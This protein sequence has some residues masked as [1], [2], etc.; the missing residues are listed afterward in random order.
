[1]RIGEEMKEKKEDVGVVIGRFQVDNLHEAHKALLNSVAES[2]GR[3]IIMIGLS[4][5][6]CTFSNPLDFDTRRA[7]LQEHYPKATIMYIN[8]IHD[9][10]IWSNDLD[11]KISNLIGPA[12]SVCMYGSR[13][14]F[15][16]Y[17]HGK[18]KTVELM[19][20]TF[21][22]GTEVRRQIAVKSNHTADFRAGAIWAMSNQYPSPMFTI[23]VAIFNDNFTKI[24]LG[25]KVKEDKYRLIGGFVNNREK[26]SAA[27]AREA[28]EETHLVLKDIKYLDSFHIKDWRYSSDRDQITTTLHTATIE[29][30]K[31]EPD[32]DI[33]ELKWFDF[34][35][36]LLNEVVP[37]HIIL[38]D[39]LL[40]AELSN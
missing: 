19:Q 16:P 17:Y 40:E 26:L 33:S 23:D 21:Y 25:K 9:D 34:N 11:K 2:H 12:Q 7:M 18:F 3:L 22:S 35:P 6:K 4:Q 1:M 27:V 14:S 24:L 30:G 31:P 13:D 15:I 5:A 38:I 28:V 37:N 8:D 20:E 36:N 39:A 10:V 32:D 29:S